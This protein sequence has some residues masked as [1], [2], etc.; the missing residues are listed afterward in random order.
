MKKIFFTLILLFS[1][2]TYAEKL[3]VHDNSLRA[4]NP[5][6]NVDT[7]LAN[8]S[9][10]NIGQNAIAGK[11]SGMVRSPFAIDMGGRVILSEASIDLARGETLS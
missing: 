11:R 8:K 9:E 4:K 2:S 3:R 1:A 6:H 10:P 5:I 7:P